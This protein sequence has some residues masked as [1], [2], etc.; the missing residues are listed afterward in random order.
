M[1]DPG[2]LG[3]W[4]APTGNQQLNLPPTTTKSIALMQQGKSTLPTTRLAPVVEVGNEAVFGDEGI[5]RPPVD[6]FTPNH[7]LEN[8]FKNSPDLGTGH[9]IYFPSA[10]GYPN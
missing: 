2:D 5:L 10:N 9:R 6:G 7:Y 1:G 8:A 3:G 4:S